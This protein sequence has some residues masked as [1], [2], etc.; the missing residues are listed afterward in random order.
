MKL[1]EE[2]L[3]ALLLLCSCTRS[4]TEREEAKFQTICRLSE[5]IANISLPFSFS[6]A[7]DGRFVLCDNE[8]VFLYSSEGRQIRQIGNK[9][10]IEM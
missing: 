3:I 4:V 1:K 10:K 6:V 9:R 7:E 8:K 2:L 5:N